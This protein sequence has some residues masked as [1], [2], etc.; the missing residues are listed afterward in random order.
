MNLRPL[1]TTVAL[2]AA[3]AFANPAEFWLD[4]V[5]GEEASHKEVFADLAQ[6]DVVYVGEAHTIDRHHAVQLGVLQELHVR[7]RALTLCMEQLEARDQAAIDRFNA[8]ALTFEQLATELGWAKKW[9]NF[10]DYRALCEFAQQNQI[11]V[12]ALN[13]PPE[14]IRAV[15]RGGGLAKL[16]PEQRALLPADIE[17]ND[18]DYE[19]LLNLQLAVHRAMDP[20]KLRSV[21]EAQV[22]RDEAMAANIA[23][24]RALTGPGGQPRTAVVVVGSGH[25]RFGLGTPPRVLRRVPGLVDRIVL[26]TESGQLKLSDTDKAAMRD[27]T[28]SHADLRALR[29]PPGDYL[30]VLPLAAPQSAAPRPVASLSKFLAR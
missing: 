12:R 26:S 19:R 16:P 13:A 10:A 21:F 17:L 9:K 29:R 8:G 24:A 15:S 1:L 25:I 5:A 6:A 22:A 14:V 4:L 11:P 27:I 20:A 23:A 3:T 30:R 2:A 7:G 28:I 18:P